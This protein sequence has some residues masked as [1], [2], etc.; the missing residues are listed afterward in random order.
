MSSANLMRTIVTTEWGKMEAQEAPIPDPGEG[1]V[2]LRT[3][4]AGI[5]GSDVHIFQGHH[6]TA[7]SPIV[8][9]HELVGVIDALG[10]GMEGLDFAEGQ[11]VVVEPLISCGVC[12]ACRRGLQH[13]CRKLKLLGIHENGAFGEYFLAPAAKLIRVPET[14]DDDIAVLTE[15][16]AVGVHVCSR[17][18]MDP[19]GRA[20]V[21]GAGPIGLVVAMVA[22]AT[23]SQVAI[24]EVSEPRLAMAKAFGF[25]TIDA[26]KDAAA[27]AST[28]SGG[29]GFDATF[30]V[31]GAAPGLSLALEATRVR[32]TI[33]QVGFFGTPPTAELMKLTLKELS[34]VGSRVYTHED[35]R[36]TVRLLDRIVAEGD[37]DLKGL[38]SE[39]TGLDGVE[40]AIHRMLAGEV[41]GKVL[42][43]PAL[44]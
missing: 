16:F 19:G 14:L 2:R 24:A 28:F 31:S 11:R 13:V 23:G 40:P 30:E 7:K 5:C 9:G 34:L 42:V 27:L 35:F 20:L 41:V 39:R 29:D 15:P 12:E 22:R 33:V 3:R 18:A 37:I 8:Q 21:I 26:K 43:D 44:T 6:P 32:G 36:R 10:P 1:Q 25:A 4:L 17:A 38:I